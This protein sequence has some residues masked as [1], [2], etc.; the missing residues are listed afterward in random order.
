[1]LNIWTCRRI[2]AL[3]CE[4]SYWYS[5]WKSMIQGMGKFGGVESDLWRIISDSSYW[6]VGWL[7]VSDSYWKHD[8]RISGYSIGLEAL[9]YINSSFTDWQQNCMFSYWFKSVEHHWNRLGQNLESVRFNIRYYSSFT[10][11]FHKKIANPR[12]YYCGLWPDKNRQNL[13]GIKS[14]NGS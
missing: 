13:E 4:I 5:Q 14:M 12:K 6:H 2:R 9:G 3:Q 11:N 8:K 10:Q 7:L 1:M